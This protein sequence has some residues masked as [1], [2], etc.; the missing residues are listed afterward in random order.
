MSHSLSNRHITGQFHVVDGHQASGAVFRII[1]EGVDQ[2]ALCLGGLIQDLIHQVRRQLLQNVDQI[3][4]GQLFHDVAD[5]TVGDGGHD[6][7]LVLGIHVRKHF[8]GNIL[9]QCSEHDNGTVHV[10]FIHDLFQNFRD[11]HLVVFQK[12]LTGRHIFLF[13][14]KLQDILDQSIHTLCY[15]RCFHNDVF[16]LH[17]FCSFPALSCHL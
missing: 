7:H 17:R 4:E 16:I 2:I 12:Q 14:Q 10:H 15:C 8:R 5:F 11:I 9:G 6:I 3:V 13:F 1:Q